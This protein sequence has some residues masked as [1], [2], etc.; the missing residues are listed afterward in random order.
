MENLRRQHAECYCPEIL[1]EKISRGKKSQVIDQFQYNW[2]VHVKS[3]GHSDKVAKRTMWN[4]F[5]DY[6]HKDPRQDRKDFDL[7]HIGHQQILL[8]L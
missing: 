5:I 4:D 1:V 7:D 6:L 8:F 3:G 2:K